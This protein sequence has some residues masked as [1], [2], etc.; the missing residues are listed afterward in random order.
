MVRSAAVIFSAWSNCGSILKDV[1]V[2]SAAIDNYFNTR[3]AIPQVGVIRF[4]S[5]GREAFQPRRRF[6]RIRRAPGP[7]NERITMQPE[8]LDKLKAAAQ[9][10]RGEIGRNARTMGLVEDQA[11]RP[12]LRQRVQAAQFH[13]ESQARSALQLAELAELLDKHP[14]VARILDLV[15][16][17][18]Y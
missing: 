3:I 5:R 17:V 18:R 7:V 12:S 13:S 9:Q 8:E 6:D 10:A 11:A 16:L 15:E 14:D 1:A 2:L 4:F